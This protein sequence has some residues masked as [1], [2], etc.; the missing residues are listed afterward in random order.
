MN[1]PK[2]W[3]STVG[4]KVLAAVTGMMLMAF[5]VIHL[6][7]NLTLFV[8]DEGA[9]FNS[10]AHHLEKLG[11]LLYAAEIGLIL[12]FLAHIVM[13]VSVRKSQLD[14]RPERYSVYASKKG[15]S[16]QTLSSR[17]M[18]VTGILLLLFIPLH[19]WMFKYNQWQEMP[20]VDLG[21]EQVKDLYLV[22]LSSFKTPAKAWA[23]VAVMLMLGLHLRH[24]FWSS[25]QSL[26]ALAPKWVP[27]FYAAGL[28]IA[29]VLAAG[30]IAM[31]LYLLYFVDSAPD[32]LRATAAMIGY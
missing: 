21:G 2:F 29:V 24:G 26:G 30:F 25:F 19:V 13:A 4:R 12:A 8:P 27:A 31:P 5:I 16:K 14:A 11:P 15:P 28:V 10:Y 9:L 7:G 3:K 32:T 6:A 20:M 23:Y 22:V 18:L 17:S 1:K